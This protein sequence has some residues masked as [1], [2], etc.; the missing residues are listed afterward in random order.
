[1]IVD[2]EELELYFPI[3]LLSFWNNHFN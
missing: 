3:K 1:M 2:V